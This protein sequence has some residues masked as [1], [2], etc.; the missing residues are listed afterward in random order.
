MKEKELNSE[1]NANVFIVDWSHESKYI[2]FS[3]SGAKV[4]LVANDLFHI[5]KYL[6]KE[7]KLKSN[8]VQLIGQGLGPQI[9]GIVGKKMADDG[10][11]IS[12]S[13]SM[14]NQISHQMMNNK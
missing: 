3:T 1:K 4:E 8:Q 9:S 12:R 14:S 7:L 6:C 10:L 2:Y 13:I 11:K 5:L